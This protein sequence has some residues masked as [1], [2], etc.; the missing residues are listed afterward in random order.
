M[1]F[2]G[3]VRSLE[4]YTYLFSNRHFWITHSIVRPSFNLFCMVKKGLQCPMLYYVTYISAA[5]MFQNNFVVVSMFYLIVLTVCAILKVFFFVEFLFIPFS[6]PIL[7]TPKIKQKNNWP[8]SGGYAG[9]SGLGVE[10]PCRAWHI[11][12]SPADTHGHGLPNGK[13]GLHI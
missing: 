12:G 3:K 5:Q 4:K 9:R 13:V 2:A 1:F 10:H 6:Y 11:S 8:L 7:N